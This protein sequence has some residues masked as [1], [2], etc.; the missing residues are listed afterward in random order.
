MGAVIIPRQAS[1]KCKKEGR[2]A[3]LR[4]KKEGIRRVVLLDESEDG[5]EEL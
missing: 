2:D 5:Q 4:L 1:N 3:A